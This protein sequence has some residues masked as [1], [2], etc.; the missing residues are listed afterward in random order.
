MYNLPHGLKRPWFNI[1]RCSESISMMHYIYA[2]SIWTY[3]YIRLGR[4]VNRPVVRRYRGRQGWSSNVFTRYLYYQAVFTLR[5]KRLN[6]EM[7]LPRLSIFTRMTADLTECSGTLT[8]STRRR[9]TR[10]SPTYL[11]CAP[12]AEAFL[13]PWSVSRCASRIVPSRQLQ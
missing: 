2:T 11:S 5:N 4:S 8:G 7:C 6:C 10:I 9:E 12:A 3:T 13:L 1:V